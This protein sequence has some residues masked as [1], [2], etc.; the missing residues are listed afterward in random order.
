RSD[1]ARR[2]SPGWTSGRSEVVVA[3]HQL[4]AGGDAK[5]GVD[6][7]EMVLDG[8]RRQGQLTRDG[9]IGVSGGGQ[10]GD[11]LLLGRQPG[12]ILA[13]AT[14]APPGDGELMMGLI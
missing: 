10:P 11:P 3:G 9:L 8:L 7:R 12:G 6:L 2:R 14:A 1:P 4:A 13:R 5:L